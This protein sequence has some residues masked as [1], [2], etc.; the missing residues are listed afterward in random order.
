[1]SGDDI[2]LNSG[3][4]WPPLIG[5]LSYS[6][7]S[8]VTYVVLAVAILLLFFLSVWQLRR[9]RKGSQVKERFWAIVCGVTLLPLLGV[10]CLVLLFG[11]GNFPFT[12]GVVAHASAVTGEEVCVVQTFKGAEPYQV[13]LYAHKPGT[14]WVWHYLA[15]QDNRWRTCRIEF[16]GDNLLVYEGSSVRKTLSLAEATAL[17]P[18]AREELPA[19]YTPKEILEHHN[20]QFHE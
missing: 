12:S 18:D 20:A 1:M 4:W 15:H 5:G 16:L 6:H 11:L 8:T 14:P 13:S 3:H 19:S 9:P 2:N 17:P 10:G 7:T